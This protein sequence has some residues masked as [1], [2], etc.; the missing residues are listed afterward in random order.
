MPGRF[1]I[2]ALPIGLG[3]PQSLTGLVA[4]QLRDAADDLNQVIESE[5]AVMWTGTFAFQAAQ[6][7]LRAPAKVTLYKASRRVRIQPLSHTSEA[8]ELDAL[9]DAI[10]RLL[11]ATTVSRH[12][13][14]K[15]LAKD[16]SVD[17][18]TPSKPGYWPAWLAPPQSDGPEGA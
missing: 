4:R 8:E 2:A 7:R 1:S 13:E 15:T 14:G 11:G 3:P 5:A 10:S 18:S 16:S 6:V 12:D 9:E 17:L